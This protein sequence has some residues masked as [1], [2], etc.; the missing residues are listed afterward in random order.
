MRTGCS[1]PAVP[2]GA[3]YRTQSVTDEPARL[4]VIVS[5]RLTR[6]LSEFRYE[7]HR[8]KTKI[9]HKMWHPD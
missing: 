5:H 4:N 1:F 2:K 3:G 6:S 7:F 9:L 8:R